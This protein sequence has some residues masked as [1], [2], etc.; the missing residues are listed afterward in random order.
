MVAFRWKGCR[1]LVSDFLN[2]LAPC[3]SVSAGEP[4]PGTTRIAYLPD[5]PEGKKVREQYISNLAA[6]SP[7]FSV[8]LAKTGH[9]LEAYTHRGSGLGSPEEIVL[10]RPHLCN[11]PN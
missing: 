6:N 1:L 2:P 10:S 7:S 3:D 11:F 5:T 4:Y 9:A 8:T